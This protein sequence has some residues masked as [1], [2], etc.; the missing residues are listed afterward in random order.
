VHVHVRAGSGPAFLVGALLAWTGHDVTA[1]AEVGALRVRLPDAWFTVRLRSL[2]SRSAEIVLL[3]EEGDRSPGEAS[4]AVAIR[5]GA[6]AAWRPGRPGECAA[7]FDLVSDGP[8]F[9]EVVDQQPGVAAPADSEAARLLGPL[10]KVGLRIDEVRPP[11]DGVATLLVWRLLDLPVTLCNSTLEHFLSYDEGRRIAAAVLE[12]GIRVAE[13]SG[14]KLAR[15]RWGDPAELLGEIRRRPSSFDAGR[16]APGR[17]YPAALQALLRGADAGELVPQRGFLRRAAEAGVAAE[18]NRRCHD[19][20]QRVSRSG[21]LPG[22][23]EL[24]RA[25]A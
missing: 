20:L 17:R 3:G 10:R 15:A 7:L 21:F 1:E 2:G 18:W 23:P 9:L 6:D 22:P 12:E 11:G 24:L 4:R 13:R 14:Q 16:Q 8:D 25:I 5:S 19:L